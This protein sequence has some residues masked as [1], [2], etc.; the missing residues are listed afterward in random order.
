MRFSDLVDE[1]LLY[2]RAANR[3]PQT[4][5][6]YQQYAVNFRLFLEERGY[7]DTCAD[8]TPRVIRE[9]VAVMQE[10]NAPATVAGKVR[11]LK[12]L[13]AWGLAEGIIVK[14]PMTRIPTPKIPQ[15]NLPVLVL[16]R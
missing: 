14:N 3:S 7:A 11:A 2:C 10:Q 1:F 15:T 6:W 5:R 8:I 12:G 9:Y 16:L 4:I 13:F